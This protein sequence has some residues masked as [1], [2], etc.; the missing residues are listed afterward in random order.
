M[1]TLFLASQFFLKRIT[2]FADA[3]T[4][5][6]AHADLA[7]TANVLRFCLYGDLDDPI[8]MSASEG[9]AVTVTILIADRYLAARS[10][11]HG[12]LIVH[13]GCGRIS[14][15]CAGKCPKNQAI[16]RGRRHNKF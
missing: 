11:P 2:A 8:A 7:Q 1:L 4:A 5:N 6:E 3:L 16:V 12:S 13:C 15:V 10:E 14:G 9:I